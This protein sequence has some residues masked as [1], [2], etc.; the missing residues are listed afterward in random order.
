MWVGASASVLLALVVT[1]FGGGGAALVA[2][3][4]WLGWVRTS[5]L[6][7][8]PAPQRRP[9]PVSFV[10]VVAV[11][12][13][14]T[15]LRWP[16]ASHDVDHYVGPDEGE[17]VENVL[18][19]IRT[20]D[21]N[22]RHRGYPGLHFYLQ[23]LPARAR[24]AATGL[25]ISEHPRSE[26]YLAARRMTLVAGA[27][28]SVVVFLAG[29]RFLSSSSAVLASTLV[30]LSPLVFRESAVVNPDLM[31]S[32]F[33]SLS[34]L[35]SLRLV[36]HRDKWSFVLAGATIGLA[37]AIKYTGALTVAPFLVATVVGG[38]GWRDSRKA[39]AALLVASLAFLVSSPYTV[40]N[41]TGF[42][43]GLSMHV[44]YYRAADLNA[45]LELT[46]QLATRG[47]FWVASLLAAGAAVRAMTVLAPHRLVV[48]AYP[49]AYWL[50]FGWFDRAFP[51][52]A[53][54]LIPMVALLAADGFSLLL[55]RTPLR[56]RRVAA[57]AF[58]VVMLVGPARATLELAQRVRR[59]TPAARALVWARDT[60]PAGSRVL[61]DQ[62]TPRLD[63]EVFQ[64]HRLRVEE[65]KFVGNY[66]WVFRSGY[67]PG[68]STD[69]LREAARFERSDGLGDAIVVYQV[70][71]R[72]MLMQE[73][74]GPTENELVIGAGELPYFGSGWHPPSGG[75]Y[76][77]SRFS[78]GGRSEIFFK[79]GV[80][81]EA[82]LTVEMRVQGLTPA[83]SLAVALNDHAVA[84]LDIG[85]AGSEPVIVRFTIPRN[86]LDT[87]LNRLVIS[88][89]EL[90]RL[91]RRHRETSIRLF[92][93]RL[94]KS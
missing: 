78:S 14:A 4:L 93:V 32:L 83:R 35:S 82:P 7:R 56:F 47:V 57:A 71:E 89:G 25:S 79:T 44:G 87:G 75:A 23:M 86:T 16:I 34:L 40:L 11:V 6:G 92:S 5:S 38:A 63:P 80:A 46:R 18:E 21:F 37:S 59:P 2:L 3:V 81:L 61:E 33:V 94:S 72:S 64:V 26:F 24:L 39:V 84:E 30:A 53:L 28:V 31:L 19:M 65:K 73:R 9:N 22:Q 70:P 76:E 50:L 45:P 27:L 91:D 67:P 1:G 49:V 29:R 10:C 51:R 88:Y 12:L 85:G 41:L 43:E 20:G 77:T 17:V 54:V 36:E 8:E 90:V 52:H 74:L 55:G 58:V 48:L 42:V 66:D 68:L 62:F 15:A 69:G 13:A 60:L